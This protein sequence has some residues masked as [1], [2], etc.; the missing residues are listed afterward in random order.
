VSKTLF[1]VADLSIDAD[2]QGRGR[3][4]IVDGFALSIEPGEI[5]GIVGESGSGKSVSLM[6]SVGLSAANLAIASGSVTFAGRSARATDRKA[7]RANLAHGVSLIFQNAKGA[8][9][10]FLRVDRQIRRVLRRLGAPSGEHAGR[11]ERLLEAVGLRSEEVAWKYPHELSG[12]QAQR[13][14]MACALSSQPRLLIADEPTTALDVTTERDVMRF[15]VGLCRERGL[16]VLLVSHNLA[17]VAEYCKRM[18]VMHAGH[19]VEE[20]Y[21]DQALSK[22]LHPYTQALIAAIPDLEEP[23]ELKPLGGDVWG[24]GFSTQQCRFSHRCAHVMPVCVSRPPRWVREDA[25][26]VRCELYA[27]GA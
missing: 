17:L 18:S 23:R 5:Y 13:V 7:L 3:R 24:G 20:G 8:L 26:A 25:Q 19:V 6:T 10:P 4:R 16:A 27:G 1:E 2:A 12:G 21:V 22:P 9:N 14:A 15:I 11:V